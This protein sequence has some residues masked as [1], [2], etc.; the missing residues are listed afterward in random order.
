MILLHRSA[1][2]QHGSRTRNNRINQNSSG[3][4]QF[5]TDGLLQSRYRNRSFVI[6]KPRMV[7]LKTSPPDY[8]LLR[9]ILR[10]MRYGL[11]LLAWNHWRRQDI[12][13]VAAQRMLLYL[14]R[15][16]WRYYFYLWKLKCKQNRKGSLISNILKRMMSQLLLKAW[17]QW[18]YLL[19]QYRRKRILSNAMNHLTHISRIGLLWHAWAIW[20]VPGPSMLMFMRRKIGHCNCVYELG[21]NKDHHCGFD[22]HMLNR[23]KLLRWELDRARESEHG[24]APELYALPQTVSGRTT[25][26][27]LNTLHTVMRKA[28]TQYQQKR[29]PS[30][31]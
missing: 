18:L 11:L 10:R 1:N 26:R 31:W 12:R 4:S 17:N 20:S 9:R 6:S 15:M 8:G 27:T 23:V 21:K 29:Q 2:A 13:D 24:T 3:G 7:V 28:P 30:Y 25:R 5:N 19:G 16:F 22:K 14:R